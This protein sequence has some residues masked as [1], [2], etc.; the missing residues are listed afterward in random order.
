MKGLRARSFYLEIILENMADEILQISSLSRANLLYTGGGHAYILMPNTLEV[1]IG[2]EQAIASINQRLAE[3]FGTR[4]Y[5]AFGIQEC[6][7]NELMSKTK[8]RKATAIF[9]EVSAQIAEMKLR[10]YSPA[11]ILKLND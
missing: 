5:T 10:R 7:A 4:L 8:I 11:E 1:R 3:Y 2:A 9:S 6:S